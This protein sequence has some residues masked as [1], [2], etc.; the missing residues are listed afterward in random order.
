MAIFFSLILLAL[1]LVAHLLNS[2]GLSKKIAQVP[3]FPINVKDESNKTRKK[4]VQEYTLYICY[5]SDN[6]V[7]YLKDVEADSITN[8]ILSY[9]NLRGYSFQVYKEKL[10]YGR[11]D[12]DKKPMGCYYIA[13][14]LGLEVIKI[15]E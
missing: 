9:V 4:K 10:T 3:E 11:F 2:F 14:P 1:L 13:I 6:S 12:E 15:K 8:A 7:S 5:E